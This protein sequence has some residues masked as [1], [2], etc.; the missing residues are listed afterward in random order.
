[1]FNLPFFIYTNI[2]K[3]K[4]KT[5]IYRRWLFG[6]N[7]DKLD[8]QKY[9]TS[10]KLFILG[11]GSSINQINDK[12]WA[13]IKK[14]DSV[15]LS[16]WLMHDFVPTYYVFEIP[17]D[18]NR[19]SIL[20]K[21]LV[22]RAYDYRN[23]PIIIKGFNRSLYYS[24]KYFDFPEA[25]KSTFYQSKDFEIKARNIYDFRKFIKKIKHSK[26]INPGKLDLIFRKRA[27][28]SYLVMFGY[29]LGYK[30]IVLLG[31]DLNNTK[32]FFEENPEYYKEKGRETPKNLQIK[33][34]VHRTLDKTFGNLTLD[35]VIEIINEE[36]LQ[37]KGVK[38]YIGS[39]NSALYPSLPLYFE[40]I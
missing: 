31:V 25:L 6:K 34:N 10:D 19:R 23:T 39:K 26:Y 18:A 12:Q 30:E 28:I 32:Y 22:K 15:G 11:S 16:F 33:D 9:K 4:V 35:I 7:L 24:D 27:S 40:K 21:L 1:M 20:N 5:I 3:L 17:R 36:I 29:L 37:P 2:L 8:Y 13:R 38:L 14:C